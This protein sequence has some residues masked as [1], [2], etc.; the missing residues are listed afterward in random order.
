MLDFIAVAKSAQEIDKAIGLIAKVIG[1]LKAQPD[2]AAQKL[3]Q[4]LDE[5]A[6]SLQVIDNAAS[7]YLSL[8]IDEGAL[9]KNSTLLLQIESG[10]LATEVR[11]G[12]GHCHVIGGIYHTYL[13]KWFSRTLDPDEQKSMRSVFDELGAADGTLFDQLAD[14]ADILQKEAEAVLDLVVNGDKAG[15]RARVLETLQ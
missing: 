1:K 12:L 13:D 10:R 5:V 15:A 7:S 8:G 11:D 4:A 3:G 2:I 14:V 6:K 9:E